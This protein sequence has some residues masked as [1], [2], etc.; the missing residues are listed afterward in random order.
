MRL[1]VSELKPF[2]RSWQIG[3]TSSHRWRWVAKRTREFP[4]K[5]TQVVKK[6]FQGYKCCISLANRLYCNLVCRTGVIFGVFWVSRGESEV[7]AKRQSCAKGGARKIFFLR[8]SPR[9]RLCS[10]KIRKNTIRL[11]SLNLR[12]LGWGGQ[13]VKNSHRL[14]CKSTQV[15]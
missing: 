4:R 9:F 10:P 11:L 3:P 8:S 7:S 12:R 15:D 6:H 1:F 14:T 2:L 5:N 13:T